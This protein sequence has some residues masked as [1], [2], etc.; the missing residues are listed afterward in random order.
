M[1]KILLIILGVAGFAS[2]AWTQELHQYKYSLYDDYFMNPAYVGTNDYYNVLVGYDSRFSGLKDASPRTLYL[3]AHSKVGQGYLF[4]KDGKINKFFSKFGNSAFGMQL[5]HFTFGA[6]YEYNLGI[7]YGYHLEL[8]PNLKT[9]RP[10]NLILAFT[11]RL[12]V[13]GVDPQKFTNNDGNDI[14]ELWDPILPTD[15]SDNMVVANF[16]ADVGALF[17]TDYYD[18]GLSFLNINNAKHNFE[19]DTLRYGV[20]GYSIYDSIYS[21]QIAVNAKI[22]DLN[23]YE[24]R[25]FDVRFEP[26]AVFLYKPNAEDF[27]VYIDLALDWNFYRLITPIRK[28]LTYNIS[29][30]LYVSHTR[31]YEPSLTLLHPYIAFNFQDFAIHYTWHMNPNVEVPG[32]WGGN[33][34]TFTYTIGRDKI[35]RNV[36]NKA[37]WK[38]KRT[39]GR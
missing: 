24:S 4:K 18:L 8:A 2:V 9:K 33:Q 21:A 10:R 14:P 28:E 37:D 22:K 35:V 34:I 36:E 15:L 20:T 26:S 39:P 29:T 25:K 1:K 31:F 5:L 16:K 13:I 7:T 23:I 12:F 32:Y 30:G 17:R 38:V 3:N 11:P 27:D 6:Q 19:Q